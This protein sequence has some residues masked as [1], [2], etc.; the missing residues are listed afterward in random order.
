MSVAAPNSSN[1]CKEKLST[2]VKSRPR[3]MRPK[4]TAVCED[5]KA[6]AMEQII[7]PAAI[8]NMTP[9]VRKM[10]AISL[11]TIPLSTIAAVKVGR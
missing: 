7:P 9:P 11:C 8:S 4:P 6:A 2:R 3:T 5:R 10:Y 1:S